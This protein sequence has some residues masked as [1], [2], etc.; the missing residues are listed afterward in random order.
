MI[1]RKDTQFHKL[2]T[3][4]KVLYLTGMP[5]QFLKTPSEK[6]DFK[7][8]KV[9]KGVLSVGVQRK[10]HDEFQKTP[11]ENQHFALFHSS[12]TDQ[13]ALQCVCELLKHHHKNGF[14]R[15]EFVSPQESIPKDPEKVKDLY[16]LLG[17]HT[18]DDALTHYVRRWVR[19]PHGAAIWVISGGSQPWIWTQEK[20]GV[21]PD[22]LFSVTN[23][24]ISVG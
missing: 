8:E 17:A 19:S 12:P 23:A 3:H 24:G 10:M 14:T 7:S 5:V 11:P 20:L 1:P 6:L 2:P 22:F 21:K 18:Q 16:I 4:L 15:F 13:W 9:S